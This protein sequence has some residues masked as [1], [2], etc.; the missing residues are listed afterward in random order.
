MTDA[1][2]EAMR[3]SDNALILDGLLDL[4][5]H[6]A[7]HPDVMTFEFQWLKKVVLERMSGDQT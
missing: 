5:A 1:M 3:A 2:S 7:T 4:A 6:R